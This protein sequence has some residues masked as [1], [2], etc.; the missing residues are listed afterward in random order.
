MAAIDTPADQSE[1]PPNSTGRAKDLTGVLDETKRF[2]KELN[3][4]LGNI[5][6]YMVQEVETGMFSFEMYLVKQL[7]SKQEELA[8]L[9]RQIEGREQAVEEDQLGKTLEKEIKWFR[10]REALLNANAAKFGNALIETKR[11]VLG[12]RKTLTEQRMELWRL[13]EENKRISLQLKDK[14]KSPKPREK[15]L[16][17][18]PE[19]VIGL[20]PPLSLL[21]ELSPKS[22]G[23]LKIREIH[24]YQQFKVRLR[25][26]KQRLSQYYEKSHTLP[27][28]PQFCLS[29]QSDLR[30]IFQSCCESHAK[31]TIEMTMP[32]LSPASTRSSSCELLTEGDVRRRDVAR[33]AADL[34]VRPGLLRELVGAVFGGGMRPKHGRILSLG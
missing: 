31:Y 24:Q 27:T 8:L 3:S 29:P 21:M 17:V 13:Q 11:R 26:A 10:V 23:S 1:D 12:L 18:D 30:Q 9:V 25:S 16:N 7:E 2:Y 32:K 4:K 15:P 34:A 5:K 28:N 20:L 14:K 6:D 19:G 22:M 33:V